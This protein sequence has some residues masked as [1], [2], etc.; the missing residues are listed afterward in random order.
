MKRERPGILAVR[1]VNQYRRRDVLAYLA[2]RYYLHNEAARTDL[3]AQQVATDL[4]LTRTDLPYLHVHHFKVLSGGATIDHRAIFL[5]SA[6][7]ALAEAALLDECSKHQAFSNPACVFSYSLSA[8]KDRSGIFPHYSAGLRDRHNAIAQACDDRPDGV[9]RYMDIKK[10]YPSIRPELALSAWKTRAQATGLENRWRMLGEKLIDNHSKLATDSNPS[11]LTGPMFSHLI[12]NLVLRQLDE[13][14]GSLPARYFRYVD[15]ITLVGS[16]KAVADSLN[17]IRAR[18]GD[19]GLNMHEDGSPKSLELPV[20]EW[21]SGRNDFRQSRREIS[22]MTLI[23]DLKRFLLANPNSHQQLQQVFRGEGFRIPVLDYSSAIYER[24]YL[25]NIKRWT[26]TRWF[27]QKLHRVS[28]DTLL[29][30][31]RWLRGSYELEFKELLNGFDEASAYE[32]K[33]RIPKLRYRAGRLSY[34]ATD[35]ALASIAVMAETVPDLHLQSLSMQ[36]M[37]SGN[38]DRLLGL[39]TNAAQ[40]TAQPMRAGGKTAILSLTTLTEAA[41]QALAVFRLN[42]VEVK[43]QKKNKAAESDLLEFAESGSNAKLMT[44]GNAFIREVTCLHGIGNGPRHPEMLE[45][46]FDEDEDLA[47]DAVDQLQQSLSL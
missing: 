19:L 18:L 7:E 23:G 9:V 16:R 17:I 36:A 38:I 21:I 2:L 5:P 3:W 13:L 20:E 26:S 29:H 30:Q 37:A 10:F 46:V 31:A 28:I 8:G 14:A 1:A 6:N 34:L 42:G 12:G 40:A 4:V 44:S 15:D 11:I 39:G 32:R 41:Q 24:S 33:R 35:E 25:E 27:R 22:W 47:V 45:S 43:A